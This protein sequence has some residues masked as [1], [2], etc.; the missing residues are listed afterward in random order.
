M[1]SGRS[2]AWPAAEAVK[3]RLDIDFGPAEVELGLSEVSE[4]ESESRVPASYRFA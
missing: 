4:G 2:L 1:A 3:Q